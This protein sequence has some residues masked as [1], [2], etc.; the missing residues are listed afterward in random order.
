MPRL[1]ASR[2]KVSNSRRHSILL[3]YFG[4]TIAIKN[5]TWPN[6]ELM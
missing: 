1:V 3:T 2:L 6:A 4:V 5:G